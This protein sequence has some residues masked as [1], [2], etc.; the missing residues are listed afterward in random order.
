MMVPTVTLLTGMFLFSNL[1]KAVFGALFTID[2]MPILSSLDRYPLV[3]HLKRVQLQL[4]LPGILP[5]KAATTIVISKLM[6]LNLSLKIAFTPF[7]KT[8]C[9]NDK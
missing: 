6:L 4:L 7:S 9:T 8:V 2:L 5:N 1:T 3:A